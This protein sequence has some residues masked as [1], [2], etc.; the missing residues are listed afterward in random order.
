MTTA[1]QG[2]FRGRS[3]RRDTDP[4]P[5]DQVMALVKRLPA[6]ARVAWSVGRDP[7][8]A[9]SRRGAMLAAAAYLISPVDLVP[10][11]IPVAGQLDDIAVVLVGLRFAMAGLSPERRRVHLAN[12]GMSEADLAEDIAAI[13]SVGWWAARRG[14]DLARRG[15]SFAT[16]H[17]RHSPFGKRPTT[18]DGYPSTPAPAASSDAI[19]AGFAE[20]QGMSGAARIWDRLSRLR[21]G[22]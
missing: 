6:Y 20:A 19:S 10:G 7:S 13:R 15:A 11:F 12:G 9:A 16:A 8:L 21:P 2:E 5:H 3:G 14:V 1:S 18:G 22:S 17:M 4:F